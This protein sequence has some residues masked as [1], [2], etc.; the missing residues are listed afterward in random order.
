M[1][2]IEK[3]TF[4]TLAQI[5]ALYEASTDDGQKLYH[6]RNMDSVVNSLMTFISAK[7]EIQLVKKPAPAVDINVNVTGSGDI[8]TKK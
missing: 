2:D 4:K 7:A 6:L 5:Q 3:S 8:E 1:L